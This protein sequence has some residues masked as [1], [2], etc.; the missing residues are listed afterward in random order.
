MLLKIDL[1]ASEGT[2]LV[3][4]DLIAVYLPHKYA[5]MLSNKVAI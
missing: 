4:Q 2:L 3:H 1:L 5:F